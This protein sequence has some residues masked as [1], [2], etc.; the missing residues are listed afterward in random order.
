MDI[1]PDKMPCK[2][3]ICFAICKNQDINELLIKCK[4]LKSYMS[5]DLD[6]FDCALDTINNL[7]R[8]G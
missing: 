6:H 8:E 1:N 4:I 7:N 2:K 5:T 3:C